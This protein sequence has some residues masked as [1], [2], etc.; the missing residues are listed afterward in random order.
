MYHL[1]L[2]VQ[3]DNKPTAKCSHVLAESKTIS[4]F[5][6]Q[7]KFTADN[8]HIAGYRTTLRRQRRSVVLDPNAQAST[9]VEYFQ[10]RNE[11]VLEKIK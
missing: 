7:K 8:R 2:C 9:A 4:K 5:S 3:A 6:C 10:Q 1:V 11:C